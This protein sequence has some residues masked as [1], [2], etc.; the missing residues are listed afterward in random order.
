MKI[1]EGIHARRVSKNKARIQF[2]IDSILFLELCANEE[3]AESSIL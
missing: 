3:N 2:V 1:N